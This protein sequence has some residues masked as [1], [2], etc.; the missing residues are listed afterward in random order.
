MAPSYEIELSE[1]EQQRLQ[2]VADLRGVSIDII[3]DQLITRFLHG[4][5]N[6]D[7]E[8]RQNITRLAKKGPEKVA[9]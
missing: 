1:Q 2:E 7:T 9:P 4:T 3:I 6:V 5:N 8:K